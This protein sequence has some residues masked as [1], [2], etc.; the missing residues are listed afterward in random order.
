MTFIQQ[1]YN[2][3]AVGAIYVAVAL[4][5]TLIY[6]L[7]RIVNFAHGQLLTLGSF[8]TFELVRHHVPFAAAVLISM[9]AVAVV[10][11]ALDLVFF[12][13]TLR[14]PLN[15]FVV[16]L[17]LIV[18]MQALFVLIWGNDQ[19]KVKPPF[20]GVFRIHKVTIDQPR[21][22][23]LGCTVV[24]VVLLFG[25][26]ERTK[27]GRGIRA[28]AEDPTAAR[29]VGVPVSPYI[30]LTFILG[31]AIAALAGGLL[32]A[33]FP[34]DAFSGF[35]FVLKGFAVAIIGGLGSVPGAV[36]AALVLSL[37]ETIGAAYFAI[38]WAPAFG[39][40][41]TA[42]III[43]RPSGLFRGAG[44]SGDSHFGLGLLEAQVHAR[45]AVL[46]HRNVA[47][48]WWR[49]D[50]APRLAWMAAAAA[51][52]A[53]PYAL[54]T[55]RALSVA[56]H[57]GILMIAAYA[58]WF[59]FRQAG[60]F[61]MA[62][63]ALIGVGAY[64][65]A[66]ALT[67]WNLGFWMQVPLAFL[68]ASA[69]A[70][71]MGAIALRTS[72]SYFVILTLVLSQ[73]CVLV[74]SNWKSMTRGAFGI[75]TTRRPDPLGPFS[76]DSPRG[77]Y[78]LVIGF[79]GLTIAALGLLS[80]TPYGRRLASLRENESL[81]RSLGIHAFRDKLIAFV[82]FGGI[83]GVAGVLLF[84]YLRFIQPDTFSVYTTIN[85]QLIV[86]LGGVSVWL[87]P[88]IGAVVFS[89]LPEVLHLN[90]VQTNLAYGMVL[91]LVI[92]TMP[93]GLGGMVKRLYVAAR[94]RVSERA[95][96]PPT[97]SGASAASGPGSGA[98]DA[99]DTRT[100]ATRTA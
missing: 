41:A 98:S 77:F 27:P 50:V 52:V 10:G 21:L 18:A 81:A 82:V 20:G 84:H 13:R 43:I 53:A 22:L 63:A 36:I 70:L 73:L 85:I 19:E 67:R 93:M 12:R 62:P 60:V 38:A 17:G 25:F 68:V 3:L 29:L 71:V 100:A 37:A 54:H 75:V 8:L 94:W 30:S 14:N 95:A 39:L 99:A 74:F 92:V 87:G 64:T 78:F 45:E 15:G 11:E 7:T 47:R 59:P 31:S 44:S 91:V 57:M 5:I 69:V 56:T 89:F 61:S 49:S 66:I 2:A 35:D 96:P 48:K 51:F 26:L 90:P 83:S 55:A 86:L 79:L 65:A 33:T 23:L 58:F 24:V 97:G 76:F 80:R 34:F 42:L 1:L 9:V 4:G 72:A 46:R 88:A 40:A 6:G 16:S 32:A 28:L